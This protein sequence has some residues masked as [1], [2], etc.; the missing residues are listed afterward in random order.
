VITRRLGQDTNPVVA[1]VI[2][3]SELVM[4]PTLLK[5]DIGRFH[6]VLYENGTK[7]FE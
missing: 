5:V 7:V 4:L 6:S 2:L 3:P 1:Y